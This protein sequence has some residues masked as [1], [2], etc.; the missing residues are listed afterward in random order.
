MLNGPVSCKLNQAEGAQNTQAQLWHFGGLAVVCW[1]CLNNNRC[2]RATDLRAFLKAGDE[3]PRWKKDA[4][5]IAGEKNNLIT[6][7]WGRE[8]SVRIDL[9]IPPSVLHLLTLSPLS[10]K[11]FRCP[12]FPVSIPFL[13][14]KVLP[15][16][17]VS[18]N[19]PSFNFACFWM[20]YKYNHAVFCDL[21][22]CSA[23]LKKMFEVYLLSMYC[24]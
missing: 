13:V 2:K 10:T 9:I 8:K 3:T 16:R 12:E 22:F 19:D 6:W 18:L 20:S 17:F 24:H 7:G 1:R 23:Y 4:L 15:H 11:G 14:F 5:C 21:L